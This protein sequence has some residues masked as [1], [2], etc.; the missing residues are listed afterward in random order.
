MPKPTFSWIFTEEDLPVVANASD[1]LGGSILLL[2][3]V[4]KKME[5]LYKCT[6]ANTAG[7]VTLN[8]TLRVLGNMTFM[9]MFLI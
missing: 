2:K 1:I 7:A 6:A 8:A 5:G 4:T 3:N 9:L